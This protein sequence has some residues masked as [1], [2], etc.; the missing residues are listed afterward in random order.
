[1]SH[2][3]S[4]SV[5]DYASI[6][7]YAE[8]G[9]DISLQDDPYSPPVHHAPQFRD[10]Y[11]EED[12]YS[13]RSPAHSLSPKRMPF[14]EPEDSI[15][16][17]L[18]EWQDHNDASPAQ[19]VD[20]DGDDSFQSARA[21]SRA[22]S[23]GASAAAV[24]SPLSMSSRPGSVEPFATKA[25]D[26][27]FPDAST[28]HRSAD[29][30]AAREDAHTG[31]WRRHT[32]R[33]RQEAA[34]IAADPAPVPTRASFR[35]MRRAWLLAALV[36]VAVLAIALGVGLGVG[37]SRSKHDSATSAS[38][39]A[40]SQWADLPK[41]D[42][43]SPTKKAFGVNLGGWLMLE[44]WMYE[45]WMV[46]VGGPNAWDEYRMSQQLGDRMVDVLNAHMDTWIT[47]PDLD[48][49]QSFGMNMLRV[50]IGY[51]P[52][53]S[54]S[55]TGE[56]YRNAT[57]LDHLSNLMYWTWKRGLYI[58]F[59]LHAMPGSQN[60]DQSS[61]H[62]DT[63]RAANNYAGFYTDENQKYSRQVVSTAIQWIEQHPA[64]S[65]VAGFT[66]VNEP[67][68]YNN[69][70]YLKTLRSFYDY[71]VDQLSSLHI[72]LVAHHAFVD[73]P[74]EQWRAY[75]RDKGPSRFIL[76]D[77]PYPAWFQNPLP[78]NVNTIVQDVCQYGSDLSGF[79][80]P[81]L[82]GE[83]SPVSILN[84]SSITTELLKTELKV[85][86]WSAGSLFFTYRINASAH[87][88]AGEA[89]P[90]ALKYSMLDMMQPQSPIAHFPRFQNQTPVSDWTNQLTSACGSA[91]SFAWTS[92]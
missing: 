84:D 69:P 3:R 15:A 54:T 29:A 28:D 50:P 22:M 26:L 6:D 16:M 60:N 30:F 25:Y 89:E 66:S 59:D 42:W 80:T 91:P 36:C 44:R 4:R 64:K 35:K 67:R 5:K 88:L 1:M 55:I 17:G 75:A 32:H 47:E 27:S 40:P 52:F 57:Q 2:L 79:P 13:D 82:I 7:P 51:W 72:P 12:L 63:R 76:D 19:Y 9:V 81:V 68:V 24:H 11:S 43:L 70:Y 65:V 46:E 83:Y 48:R 71:T 58:L 78:R 56:P 41:W 62:N 18:L 10:P 14:L 49:I 33:H 53:L 61:G 38:D 77:H 85:F 20:M 74:Y 87:P 73:K 39:P 34:P 45:D 8:D 23:R 92:S 31:P 37:L 90:I 21:E 86:G